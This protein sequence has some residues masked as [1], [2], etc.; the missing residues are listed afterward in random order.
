MGMGMGIMLWN[1]VLGFFLSCPFVPVSSLFVLCPF[2]AASLS[3]QFS[4][5]QYFRIIHAR[6]QACAGLA[7]KGEARG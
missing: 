2:G 6:S 3:Q 1:V 7:V 4:L 5:P